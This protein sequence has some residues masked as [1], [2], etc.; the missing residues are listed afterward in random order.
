MTNGIEVPS[1]SRKFSWAENHLVNLENLVAI[2]VDSNPYEV[3][4]REQG[5]GNPPR[6]FV[7]FTA[8][9]N[10]DI[11]LVAGDFLYN[12]RSGL[13]HLVAALVPSSD[14]SH[15]MFP[16]M[17]E[18]IWDIPQV[19]GE[20]R[21]RTSARERWT[22]VTRKMKPEAVEILKG[23]QP[24]DRSERERH[25]HVI[26]TLNKLS[27]KDRH[28]TLHV[29]G[30]GIRNAIADYGM[31]DGRR[32]PMRSESDD[33]SG[34]MDGTELMDLPPDAV[35]VQL[36]GAVQVVIDVGT[37]NRHIPIPESFREM[38]TVMRNHLVVPLTPYLHGLPE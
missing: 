14:R 6:W 26:Q 1:Y 2:Y 7:H 25:V 4:K 28:R 21:E 36:S 30:S 23:A 33:R 38:L 8:Q 16:I 5:K 18:A 29:I 37:E 10:P 9:P 3:T 27:N 32:I 34:P 11:A 15:V 31:P 19:D 12:I 35:D 20:D 22:T 24:T 17:R 13:D